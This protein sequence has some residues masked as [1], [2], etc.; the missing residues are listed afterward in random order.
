LEKWSGSCHLLQKWVSGVKEL[1]TEEELFNNSFLKKDP[2]SC[3]G[4][5]K[6]PDNYS[7]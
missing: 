1:E 2:A 3:E 5:E 7:G 4:T 6:P